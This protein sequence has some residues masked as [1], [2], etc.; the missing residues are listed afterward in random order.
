MVKSTRSKDYIN[1]TP[2]EGDT[3]EPDKLVSETGNL[4]K[5]DKAI[6]RRSADSNT[7]KL[8][9]SSKGARSPVKKVAKI[10][11]DEIEQDRLDSKLEDELLDYTSDLGE[12]RTSDEAAMD[13]DGTKVQS[14]GSPIFTD[15]ED[16]FED[17]QVKRTI[18]YYET[19]TTPVNYSEDEGNN[20]NNSN[21]TKKKGQGAKRSSKLIESSDS[22]SDS[23]SDS[24][25]S[26]SSS[27]EVS[28]SSDSSDEECKSSRSRK[29]NKRKKL[30]KRKAK[31]QAKR[32]KSKS[33]K[34]TVLKKRKISKKDNKQGKQ[35][36]Y[37]EELKTLRA[38]LENLKKQK[39]TCEQNKAKLKTKLKDNKLVKNAKVKNK[40][41]S[42]TSLYA[43]AVVIQGKQNDTVVGGS[44]NMIRRIDERDRQNFNEAVVADYLKRVRLHDFSGIGVQSERPEDSPNTSKARNRD[45]EPDNVQKARLDAEANIIAAEKYK[46][47]LA[48]TGTLIN[49]VNISIPTNMFQDPD[50]DFFH[51]T[52]HIDASL[53]ERI[54]RGEFVEL[55]KLLQKKIKSDSSRN[56]QRLEI[57]NRDGRAYLTPCADKDSK[58]NGIGRWDQGLCN[59]LLGGKP[60]QSYRDLAVH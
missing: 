26:T 11:Q 42:D 37:L 47:S 36:D 2:I 34:Q 45:R 50:D 54:K 39:G 41:H 57:C 9:S 18:H 28:S 25:S 7:N 6:K 40:A 24:S 3:S 23:A 58:I 13:G 49:P 29:R 15:G 52:C 33:K 30:W 20:A 27:S 60:F 10:V 5:T 32:K 51:T 8:E 44:P 21:K 16:G 12:E 1:S 59:H 38:E 53:K 43:P 4:N 14:N 19:V 46:A 56:E 48:P 35:E 55:E 31:Q 17:V 22:S